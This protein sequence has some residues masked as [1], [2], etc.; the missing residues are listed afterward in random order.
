MSR[1]IYI[2]N[3]DVE[4]ALKI[5]L[6]NIDFS[7][8]KETISVLNCID[9]VTA[10]SV[11]SKKSSPSYSASAMDGILI[12][13]EKTYSATEISPIFLE[14]NTD[15]IYIN[16]GNPI[17]YSIGNCVIMIE[18]VIPQKDGK[19]KLIKSA[20]PWQNIRPVGE[21]II[22]GEMIL[23]E[24]HQI[25]PLDLGALI[26]SLVK[27]VEVIKKPTVAIIP[28][29]NEVIDI[30][31]ENFSENSV[32]DSN[33]YVFSA[34]IKEWG[35]EPTILPKV[36]DEKDTIEKALKEA[37]ESFD[38]VIICAGSSAGS[39]DFTREIIERVGKV[40]IHGVAMKP[41]KPTI[42]GT[43]KNKPVFG[44]PGYPV[45][46]YLSMETF[47]KPILEKATQIN[48]EEQYIEASLSKS[49]VSSLKHKELV[50]MSLHYID[51]QLI[52]TPLS[53]G[54]G[55]T[56]SL[57]KADGILEIP[58]N[59]EGISAGEIV[60][61]KLLKPLKE[62]RDY[63]V[64]TGSHDIVMDLISDK[65]KLVSTHVGSFG[66]I[67]AIKGNKTHIAPIHILDENTGTYNIE[68][69]KKYFPGQK[70]ALIKGI[71]RTQGFIVEKGNPLNI[72]SLEDLTKNSIKFINRQRGAGTRIL[73]DFMLK[74]SNISSEN[75][76]GYDREAATHLE[77]AMAIKSK[78]ADVGIGIK[79]AAEI[80]GLDFIPIKEEEYDFL[81]PFSLLEDPKIIEFITFLKSPI[82][83]SKIESL[84]GYKLNASGDVVIING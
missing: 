11:F 22:E 30:F 6:E 7:L 23:K 36:P 70:I 28:S 13:A 84:S 41:G 64:S 78:T 60:K 24:G 80:T 40:L 62:I 69:I 65:I 21:D 49:I 61:I 38:I 19:V 51:N 50:R 39:K 42:L 10:T 27:E 57:V 15:F 43:V 4:A 55:V 12:H 35:G 29:G 83:K 17:D 1:N 18:E 47:V 58:K 67:L 5:L 46:A 48:I 79:E 54:A 74:S 37:S 59:I 56:M 34:L 71:Y 33:S 66:G 68:A 52:A 77:V 16:T 14:P 26:S 76:Y 9:R 45:S 32:V 53:R 25:K 82:F 2:D 8:K 3:T 63:L 73:L 44:I 31:K 20:K 81:V 75:I 72:K